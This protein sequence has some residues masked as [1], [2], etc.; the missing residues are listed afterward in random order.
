[1]NDRNRIRIRRPRHEA[2]VA[3]FA[4]PQAEREPYMLAGGPSAASTG[5]SF[6]RV[7]VTSHQGSGHLDDS[8][9][10]EAPKMPPPLTLPDDTAMGP[11][12][13]EDEET[14]TIPMGSGAAKPRRSG[15]AVRIRATLDLTSS[16]TEEAAD[17][18]KKSDFGITHFEKPSY[19]ARSVRREH[20]AF[21]VKASLASDIHIKVRPTLGP[22][23]QVDIEGDSDSDIT[24]ENYPRIVFDFTPYHGSDYAPCTHFWARDLTS[25]HERFH[26]NEDARFGKEGTESVQS[27][28][29]GLKAKD[30]HDVDALLDR[31]P[32]YIL[33]VV[34]SNMGDPAEKRAYH[35]GAPEFK[36][37][38]DAIQKKG[39]GGGYPPPSH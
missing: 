13:P 12:G 20:G 7:A 15:G 21:V 26:A 27:Q 37:R 17:P 1:M 39:D 36:K 8:E 19:T 6:G 38:A 22:D 18:E 5:H 30:Q 2:P 16:I 33:G 25:R 9:L 31:A 14:E 10:E 29:N 28:L 35:D 32:D 24:S 3:S 4:A 23:G 11:S 34:Q